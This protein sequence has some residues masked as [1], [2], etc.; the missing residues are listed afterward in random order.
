MADSLIGKELG[1]YQIEKIIGQGGQ[2]IVYKSYQASMDRHVAIKVLPYAELLDERIADRFRKEAQTIAKLEHPYI[3]PVY[4][5]GV[6]D[7]Y[8]YI[9][10]RYIENGTLFD[11][12]R[13]GPT[14][15][16][17]IKAILEQVGD[18]L[19]FAHSRHIIHR[20]IKP[21]NILIDGAGHGFLSDFGIAKNTA[22]AG[23]LTSLGK[24]PGTPAYMS[25]EQA[26]GVEVDAR[27]DIY[28]LGV[29]LFQALTKRLPFSGHNALAVIDQHI[30]QSPP[31]LRSFNRDIPEELEA[32]VLKALAKS[33]DE[34]Y[35]SIHTFVKAFEEAIPRYAETQA[36]G[37]LEET[38][39]QEYADMVEELA[40]IEDRENLIRY[41]RHQAEESSRRRREQM[42]ADE[43]KRQ[44]EL[45]LAHK[46]QL[47][48]AIW[49]WI[50]CILL[51]VGC[52]AVALTIIWIQTQTPPLEAPT[53]GSLLF[54]HRWQ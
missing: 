22:T 7:R 17:R 8:F 5:F 14:I 13:S 41:M 19:E 34:R 28:S 37:P 30:N 21:Q 52:V 4:D 26:R 50:I 51:A 38:S 35:Q 25:P 53:P 49:L 20:D 31:A 54:F 33:P 46:Q 9:V 27:S 48:Q 16:L 24:I 6:T 32:V 2:A 1:Q 3:L 11:L 43:K 45:V 47:N 36:F 44:A 10:M 40:V 18:A 23:N 42:W 29:V 12:L 39:V 15:L